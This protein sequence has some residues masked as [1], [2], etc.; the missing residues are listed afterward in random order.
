VN[1]VSEI[2]FVL[3]SI[4]YYIISVGILILLLVMIFRRR[5]RAFSNE[6]N[7]LESDKNL[8]ISASIISEL[9]KVEALL[10]NEQ[11]QQA[12]EE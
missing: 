2:A 11:M 7:N 10:N 8:I 12:F 9:G 1:N 3:L 6:I 4:T 5:K